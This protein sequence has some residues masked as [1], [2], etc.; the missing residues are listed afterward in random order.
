VCNPGMMQAAAEGSGQ[1]QR[2][3]KQSLNSPH[4]QGMLTSGHENAV[5]IGWA[6]E[7]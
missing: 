6:I 3:E 5:T 7:M 1:D 2:D 4:N